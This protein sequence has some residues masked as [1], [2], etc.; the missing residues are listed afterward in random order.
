MEL[1]KPQDLFSLS[2]G[3]TITKRNLFDLI[4]FSKVESSPYWA[5]SEFVIG[6]T[7]Q[8][9]INWIG[10]LPAVK[11]VTI[12]T[13]PGSY[14]EDGWSDDKKTIYHYS[15]KARNSKVSYKEKANEVLIKQP[16]HL[17]PVFLFTESKESWYF[18]GAFSVS[19]IEDT[20]VVLHRGAS[21]IAE[22][23][24]DQDEAQYQEGERRYV[25]HLM[26][27]RSKDVVSAIKNTSVWL[28]EICKIDFN[29]RYGVHY[30]EAHHKV[31]ISTYS[32]KHSI[33]P[34]DLALL[35]PNCHKAVHVYMKRNSLEYDEIKDMLAEKG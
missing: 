20:Y 8:Q 24:S 1:R 30:I 23:T 4:Q 15:F 26:A 11:A 25:T 17:Y 31:P 33:K 18:E 12:K 19:E 27:E 3:D 7:P 6:N 34:Q 5:G 22:L 28:C 14:K 29:E 16:Q 13:R 32:S 10:N 2:S 9:G 35:C 21:S